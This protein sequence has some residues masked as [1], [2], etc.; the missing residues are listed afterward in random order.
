MEEYTQCRY[1]WDGSMNN[2]EPLEG[3]FAKLGANIAE[4]EVDA[5]GEDGNKDNGKYHRDDSEV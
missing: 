1:E 2:E 5:K 3:K 4:R